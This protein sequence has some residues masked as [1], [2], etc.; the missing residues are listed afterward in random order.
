MSYVIR[1][2]VVSEPLFTPERQPTSRGHATVLRSLHPLGISVPGEK[3]D[4]AAKLGERGPWK[5]ALPRLAN[6]HDVPVSVLGQRYESARL[7]RPEAC[8]FQSFLF[9]SLGGWAG[10][11]VG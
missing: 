6:S 5:G 9:F 10:G 3:K 4:A 11:W 1:M 8:V 7:W 2:K